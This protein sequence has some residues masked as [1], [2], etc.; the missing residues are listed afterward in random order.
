MKNL[1]I[2]FVI[3]MIL[4]SFSG[5]YEKLDKNVPTPKPSPEVQTR[6]AD[7]GIDYKATEIQNTTAIK[8]SLSAIVQKVSP[9]V[10]GLTVQYKDREGLGLGS[11]VI[12]HSDG[13][14]ITNFH[15]AGNS[16]AIEIIL[17][18]TTK[19]PAQ[20]IWADAALDLAIVKIEGGPYYG[21][22]LGSA[23]NAEVGD[24]VLAF[25][26]P[27]AL[28]FQHTV[29]SGIVSA[30]NRTLSI[31][32][33][34][35]VSFMEDLLQTDASI[36]PGNS[37]GPLVNVKGEVIG[38]NTLKVTDAE[39]LGFAIPIDIC[40]PIVNHIVKNGVY[41]TPYLGVLT[42]DKA[43]AAYLGEQIESGVSIRVVDVN[44][45]G[46]AS[47]LR[48]G[49]VIEWVNSVKVNSVLDLRKEI[50]KTGVDGTIHIEFTRDGQQM[51]TGCTLGKK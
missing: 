12:A 24:T 22:K 18:D 16:N 39:G 28:K 31:P 1:Y 42:I 49:D 4:L 34:K 50:Y 21:A 37:G 36:N 20:I 30:K 17:Y 40:V 47:G 48:Q 45:P 9:A 3:L 23:E 25:G 44:S 11:G 35:S 5:C 7:E 41:E 19:V 15:V 14:I 8:G 29:T 51:S 32:S 2:I 43:I 33:E 26:T 27:L 6:S 13:Y 38:I 10:V 46:Y